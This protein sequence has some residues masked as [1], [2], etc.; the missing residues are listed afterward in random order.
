MGVHV[1]G[2]TR[3][4]PGFW[5]LVGPWIA[6]R[7]VERD[8]GG[9]PYDDDGKTWFAA[10]GDDGEL[11]GFCAAAPGPGGV[12]AYQSDW[13]RPACR[14]QGVHRALCAA[15]AAAFPGP[16]RATCT[17]ASLP[18][19]LAAGF[20]E[21]RRKGSFTLVE[22]DATGTEPVM[23]APGPAAAGPVAAARE[24][25]A[26]LATVPEDERIGV[27]NEIRVALREYSPMKGEP[28]DCVLWVP[29]DQVHG[30]AY[31]PNRV[32]APEM[33]LLARSIECD[34][35]T[36]PIVGWPA[37]GGWEVVDG[38]HRHKVGKENRK[39]RTRVRGHLP[40]APVNGDR[41]ALEDRM[42]ATIRHN[43]A[44]GRHTVDGMAEIVLDLARRNHS[45]EW[46]ARELGMEP[47]EVLRLKQVQA[48]AEL[49]AGHE[50]NEAWEA[51]TWD[52]KG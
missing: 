6:R 33:R 42:A 40:V 10:L 19:Y 5:R 38:F 47:D 51:D 24:A 41:G 26:A 34:G 44:R 9:R 50:F 32:A 35:F 8:L 3:D 23:A 49:F 18:A 39:V 22:R 48:M 2:L 52:G 4:D 36:Q 29:A 12:T 1:T 43:R 27:I 11:L 31:N 13:V 28:V 46:I 25:F 14:R 7:E 20:R 37:D 30:N 16:A 15:R 21:V 45:D 17:A